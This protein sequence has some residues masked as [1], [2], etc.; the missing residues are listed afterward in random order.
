MNPPVAS[1]LKPHQQKLLEVAAEKV[2]AHVTPEQ[3]E[4]HFVVGGL[5][6]RMTYSDYLI[7]VEQAIDE[8]DRA[9][10]Q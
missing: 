3:R 5:E 2:E 8:A 4:A 1:E 7:A 10:S 6:D 9:G